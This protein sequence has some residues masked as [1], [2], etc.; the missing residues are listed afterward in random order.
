MYV[1]THWKTFICH[2]ELGHWA[3]CNSVRSTLLKR[4][5][6]L[7]HHQP[8]SYQFSGHLCQLKLQV[9]NTESYINN[10]KMISW[11]LILILGIDSTCCIHLTDHKES[12][13]LN[14]LDLEPIRNQCYVLFLYLAVW[15]RFSKLFA[16]TQVI[17]SQQHSCVSCSKGARSCS[18]EN[19]H[20]QCFTG[21]FLKC[22]SIKFVE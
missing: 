11:L 17:S 16:H 3:E 7:T 9:L 1:Y 19:L 12:C 20:Q 8:R 13:A 14:R 5:C 6:C 10:T 18:Q 22:I 4:Q 21:K 2:K 15:K